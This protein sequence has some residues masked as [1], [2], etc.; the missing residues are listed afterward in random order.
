MLYC[1]ANNKLDNQIKSISSITIYLV[2]ICMLYLYTGSNIY[3][4]IQL[5]SIMQAVKKWFLHKFIYV[6][7]QTVMIL[8][9]YKITY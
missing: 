1:N 9:A 6:Y 8:Q 5:L 2:Y 4:D 7:F 3:G